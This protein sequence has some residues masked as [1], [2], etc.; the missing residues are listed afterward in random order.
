MNASG[1]LNLHCRFKVCL[2]VGYTLRLLSL[3]Y[4]LGPLLGAEGVWREVG[5]RGQ[6]GA[7]VITTMCR[8]HGE[9]AGAQEEGAWRRL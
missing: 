5:G 7:V 3:S 6:K 4:L 2:S 9:G 1:S 8:V